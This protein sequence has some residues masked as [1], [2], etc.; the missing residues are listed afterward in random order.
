MSAEKKQKKILLILGILLSILTFANSCKN[1]SE[2]KILYQNCFLFK[3][4]RANLK[5]LKDTTLYFP[6]QSLSNIG[7]RTT[8]FSLDN[9]NT[10]KEGA[11]F[12][13]P[14]SFTFK[15]DETEGQIGITLKHIDND[16]LVL[17]VM[18]LK[19]D[20]CIGY[21]ED[22]IQTENYK[23]IRIE[24]QSVQPKQKGISN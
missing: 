3:D 14:E 7:E 19:T 11:N 17:L 9:L 8:T 12:I 23:S 15:S 18:N 6:I 20:N 4:A 16:S 5:I 22:T 10:G 24:Y 1:D 13:I 21:A 2:S